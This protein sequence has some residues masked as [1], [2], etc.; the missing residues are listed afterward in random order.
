[1]K[2]DNERHELFAQ[3]L[4]KGIPQSKAYVQAGFEAT[5]DQAI[6]VN[7]HKLSRKTAVMRRVTELQEAG[8]RRAEREIGIDKAWIMLRLRDLSEAAQEANQYGPSVRAVELMGRERGMFVEKHEVR[9]G[10][11]EELSIADLERLVENAD[12]ESA[13]RSTIA[14]ESGDQDSQDRN[15]LPAG[16]AS[17]QAQLP[18]PYGAFQGGGG[19]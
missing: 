8:A 3:N 6:R 15:A 17:K 18:A 11:L 10:P 7:A 12:A 16:W 2:L 19:S 1:L 9:G 4:A 14:G 5:T 13:R